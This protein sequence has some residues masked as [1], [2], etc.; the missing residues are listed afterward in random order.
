MKKKLV[1]AVIAAMLVISTLA[2][3]ALAKDQE[4]KS[5]GVPFAQIWE[6][7]GNLREWVV[8]QI[9]N[10]TE[11]DPVYS[12]ST[13]S[14]INAFDITNWNSA[15]GWGDHSTQGY[16]KSVTWGDIVSIPPDIADGDQTGSSLW[17]QNGTNISYTD[18]RVGIGTAY[19]S[20]TLDVNGDITVP[21]PSAV[22]VGYTGQYGQASDWYPSNY[23]YYPG[24][25]IESYTGGEG[26]GIFMNGDTMVM[27]SPGDDDLLKFYDEDYLPSSLNGLKFRID[28]G[29]AVYASGFNTPSD[30]RL[31]ENIVPV[32]NALDMVMGLNGIY[33]NRVVQP[34]EKDEAP[35]G[36]EI[37]LIA[38]EVEP[39]LPEV[40]MEDANGYKSIN[41]DRLTALLIEAIKELKA[42]NDDLRAQLDEIRALSGE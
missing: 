15:F 11:S 17:N 42:D 31:K 25:I 2:V 5:N 40:V 36:R 29:G 23:H 12:A 37:G 27:W 39:I 32:E 19:P 7:L 35:A 10:I 6:E 41:Y 21:G 1:F 26:S 38:Q 9:E 8:Q 22:H 33:Y 14:G 18:G 34:S 3:P 16:L 13:A 4:E 30:A 28:Y 20:S 24:L